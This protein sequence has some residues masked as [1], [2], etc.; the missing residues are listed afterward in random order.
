M[1]L[2]T[3]RHITVPGFETMSDGGSCEVIDNCIKKGWKNER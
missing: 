2:D 3:E 1:I